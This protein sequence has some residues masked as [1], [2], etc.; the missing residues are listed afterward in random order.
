MNSTVI[1]IIGVAAALGTTG[2]WL[3]QVLKTWRSRSAKD[4]SWSYLS[5]FSSGVALWIGY[6]I[7][8]KDPVIIAANAV[9]LLLVLTVSFVKLREK[10]R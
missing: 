4:F 3:P 5:I 6:G 2:A 8:R 7:L 1:T 9:T 10:R